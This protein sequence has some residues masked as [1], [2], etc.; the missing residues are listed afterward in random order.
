MRF[1]KLAI[2]LATAF[3]A[4]E[5]SLIKAVRENDYQNIIEHLLAGTSLLSLVQANIE[6]DEVVRRVDNPFCRS[7]FQE[8]IKE[9][10]MPE[11]RRESATDLGMLERDLGAWR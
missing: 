8:A 11:M 6:L 10:A 5:L 7:L 9:L 3:S 4:G 2:P 1:E